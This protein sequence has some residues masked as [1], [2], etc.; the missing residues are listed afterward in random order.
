MKSTFRFDLANFAKDGDTLDS[1]FIRM[2]IDS[3]NKVTIEIPQECQYRTD[4]LSEH[5]YGNKRLSWIFGMMNSILY[6]TELQAGRRLKI[7]T[8]A[9]LERI[10]T[11]WRF[12]NAQY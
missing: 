3:P 11:K 6:I 2:L 4:L 5:F 1:K 8:L 7:V 9:D 10:Y 12:S